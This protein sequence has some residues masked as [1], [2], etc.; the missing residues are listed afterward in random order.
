M[1][2]WRYLADFS[3][4]SRG[5]FVHVNDNN[6]STHAHGRLFNVLQLLST[7]LVCF[8]IP[9]SVLFLTSVQS[10]VLNDHALLRRKENGDWGSCEKHDSP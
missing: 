4:P 2:D 3:A 5:R 8:I 6:D 10:L 9:P 1:V 7:F